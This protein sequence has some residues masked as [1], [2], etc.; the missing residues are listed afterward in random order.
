M[1][2]FTHIAEEIE[3]VCRSSDIT[4]QIFN[5]KI[6]SYSIAI[7]DVQISIQLNEEAYQKLKLINCRF[8]DTP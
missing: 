5:K 1:F 6:Y 7:G 3:E 4:N 2:A 8:C